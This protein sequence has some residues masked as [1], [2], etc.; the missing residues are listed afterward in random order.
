MALLLTNV[1]GPSEWTNNTLGGAV[2]LAV[3]DLAAIKALTHWLQWLRAVRLHV[4]ISVAAEAATNWLIW[5]L[6][7]PVAVPKVRNDLT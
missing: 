7:P 2:C 4:I 5:A 1:A 6:V 3:A